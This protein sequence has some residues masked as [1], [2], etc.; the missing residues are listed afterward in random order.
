M[1]AN[2]VHGFG[3][4]AGWAGVWWGVLL[5]RNAATKRVELQPGEP[6]WMRPAARAVDAAAGLFTAGCGASIGFWALAYGG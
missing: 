6:R 2:L 5:L 4:V 1:M 3:M